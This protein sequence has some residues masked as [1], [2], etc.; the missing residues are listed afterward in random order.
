MTA[1]STAVPADFVARVVGVKTA[2]KNLRE[3]VVLLP[4]R[5]GLI[6]QG[7]TLS[8]YSLDKKQFLNAVEVGEDYGFGSPLHLAARE[9]FPANNDGIGTIPLTVFPLADGTTASVGDLT[10]SGGPQTSTQEYRVKVNNIISEPIVIPKDTVF[11]DTVALIIAGVNAN[12][13]MPAL[14][15]DGTGK[16]DF[17]AKWQGA[18]GDD[19]FIEIIGPAAGITYAITQPTGGAGNLSLIHISEPTRPY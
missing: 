18:S 7:A 16:V 9:F 8:T 1:I 14:A 5:I 2:Y 3:G 11:G 13:N 17:T 10:P 12:I 4:Q 19:L 6:G 15:S